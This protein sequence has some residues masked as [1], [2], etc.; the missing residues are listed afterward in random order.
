M[1]NAIKKF[2]TRKTATPKAEMQYPIFNIHELSSKTHNIIVSQGICFYSL[3][4]S[5][6]GW[7]D[8]DDYDT[9][10]LTA[11]DGCKILNQYYDGLDL[12][13]KVSK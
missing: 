5:G 9:K 1:F 11:F 3:D 2:F 7:I 4:F 12:C 10:P 13:I 8:L 6:K